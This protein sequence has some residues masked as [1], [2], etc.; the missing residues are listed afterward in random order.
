MN[1]TS[2]PLLYQVNTR[3][4]LNKL[5]LSAGH[6]V[7]LDDIPDSELDRFRDAGFNWI[8]LL[9]VWQTGDAGRRISRSNQDWRKEFA[10][11]LPD[12]KEEDIDGSGFAIESYTVNRRIGDEASLERLRKKLNERGIK[13]MLDFVPNHTAIDNE[14]VGLHPGF[15]IRGQESD[16][17]KYPLNYTRVAFNGTELIFAHGRDPYFPGWP[18]TLQLNYA[19]PDLHE[20]MSRELLKIG[21]LCDG[22]RC[23]MAML[24]LPDVFERTWGMKCKPF[25]PEAIHRVKAS[26]PDFCMMAEVYWDMEYTLLQQGFDYAYDKRLYDRLKDGHAKSVREHFFAGQDYQSKMTRFLENHDEQRAAS[27]FPLGKHQAAAVLTYLSPGMRFF[28]QGQIDGMKKKVSPHLVRAAD[29]ENDAVLGSFYSGLLEMLKQPVL[30]NGNWQLL[31]CTQAWEGNRTFE[32]Y[33]AF[34]WTGD[35]DERIIA[36]V[37]YSPIRSQCY[38]RLPFTRMEGNS[39]SFTD[40]LTGISYEREGSDLAARGLYI[41]EPAWKIYVFRLVVKQG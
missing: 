26:Y 24:L 9:S 4:W 13:L 30:R 27:C 20:A 21:G 41:D 39:W 32:K 17:G 2:F 37:N 35:Q 36:I 22:V 16:I 34:S 23:D 40:I 8:W 1:K 19:N 25:W 12:L 31:T 28:H 38:V 6:E 29:E 33:I 7:K 5:G 15:F 11:T 3:V 10:E 18:D 14:W